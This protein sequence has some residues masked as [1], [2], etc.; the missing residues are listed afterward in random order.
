MGNLGKWNDWYKNISKDRVI[1]LYG[2][3]DSY[4]LGANFLDDCEVV[5]DWGV[6]EGGFKRIREDAIGIDGSNTPYADK[7]VD[8]TEYISKCDGIFIRHVL[9]HNFDWKK[10]LENALASADKVFLVLFTSLAE[11]ETVELIS[12]SEANRKYGVDV[13][14]LSLGR[15]EIYE[16]LD[17]YD[18]IEEEI[19]SETFF[20]KETIFR[21]TKRIQVAKPAPA[22][23]KKVSE[24]ANE[25]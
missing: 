21:I 10:I 14:S 20:G 11:E 6:G 25:D 15:E 1:H 5:E 13:P 2:I 12:E 4:Q 16:I 18:F 8:L 19:T 3:S 17:G 23:K 24:K 7:I 22:S 9:E